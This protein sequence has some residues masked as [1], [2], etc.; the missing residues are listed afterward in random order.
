MLENA[1][2]CLPKFVKIN[3]PPVFCV[4]ESFIFSSYFFVNVFFSFHSFS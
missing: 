3:N 4:V 2:G 1:G